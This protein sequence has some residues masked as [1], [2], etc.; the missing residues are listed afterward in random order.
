MSQQLPELHGS[1][2]FGSAPETE[3]EKWARKREG[4]IRHFLPLAAAISESPEQYAKF[5]VSYVGDADPE[6]R[7]MGSVP[8]IVRTRYT[9]EPVEE[10]YSCTFFSG[11][12]LQGDLLNVRGIVWAKAEPAHHFVAL[13]DGDHA[14]QEPHILRVPS[15]DPTS[16]FGME[17]EMM[18]ERTRRNWPPGMMPDRRGRW[19][20]KVSGA[21]PESRMAVLTQPKQTI[22]F[23]PIDALHEAILRV[24]RQIPV[25]G[26]EQEQSIQR[27]HL[28]L[29]YSERWEQGV[30]Q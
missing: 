22:T 9:P 26:G 24:R 25:I 27:G 18:D 3:H 29:A 30:P 23:Y 21:E 10:D 20:L 4:I 2:F 6:L 11:A 8:D 19:N 17:L 15:N 7:K 5:M 12:S 1:G 16:A 13:S 14:A 28:T